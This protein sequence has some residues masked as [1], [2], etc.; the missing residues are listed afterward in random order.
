[1]VASGVTSEQVDLQWT[2]NAADE[3]GFEVVSWDGAEWI[4]MQAVGADT[5]AVTITRRAPETTYQFSVRATNANGA[6][7]LVEPV[8]VRT[9]P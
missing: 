6:S 3:D 1:L 4:V 5:T 9:E 2:D 7:A 8:E